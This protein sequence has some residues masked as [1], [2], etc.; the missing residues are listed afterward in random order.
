MNREK[1]SRFEK[2]FDRYEVKPIVAIV[3][4]NKDPQLG[5]DFSDDDFWVKVAK[6]QAKSCKIALHEYEK[7]HQSLEDLMPV[8]VYYDRAERLAA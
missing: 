7:K 4:N 6:W 2:L 8:Q 1:W 3:P 5:I